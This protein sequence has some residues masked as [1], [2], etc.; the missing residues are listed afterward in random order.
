MIKINKI[1]W[2]SK[3]GKEAE[4]FLYDGNFNM[5]CYSHPFN[6]DIGNIVTQPLYTLNA[7]KILILKEEE[8]FSVEKEEGTFD[9]KFAGRL[10]NK[11]ENHVKLGEFIIELDNPVP[12]DIQ[13][14]DYISFI[15][16]RVD[17]Y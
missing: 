5:V 15:C 4:V 2:L 11:E 16:D 3:V 17:I 6:Q 9:Y 1:N 10:I 8:K 14:G 7:R 13:V 12:S